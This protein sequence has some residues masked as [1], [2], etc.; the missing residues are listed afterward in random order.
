MP[1]GL[2]IVEIFMQAEETFGIEIDNDDAGSASTV[3]DLYNLVLKE[4][5]KKTARRPKI[6]RP[7]GANFAGSLSSSFRLMKKT[8]SLKRTS[9]GILA[10]IESQKARRAA[11]VT[12]GRSR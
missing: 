2:D 11:R 6:P 9:E 12:P 1:V 8:S 3:G 10:R 4:L 7:S 5:E